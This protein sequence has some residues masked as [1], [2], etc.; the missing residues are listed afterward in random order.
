M[1]KDRLLK[2]IIGLQAVC[3][4]VLAVVVVATVL[5]LGGRGDGKPPKREGEGTP[6][7]AGNGSDA[8]GLAAIATVGGKPITMKELQERLYRQYG[9]EVLR[10]MMVRTAIDLE[11]AAANIS[12]TDEEIEADL[13]EQMESYGG[14]EAFY[15]AMKSQLGLGRDDVRED[16]KYRLLLEK[17]ATRGITVSDKEVDDYL[18]E[19]AEEY[20]PSTRLHLRWIVTESGKDAETVLDKLENGEDFGEL[21]RTYSIDAATSA[22]GGDLGEIDEEDGFLD[23]SILRVAHDLE[24]GDYAGPIATAEGPAVI[25]LIGKSTVEQADHSTLRD[26]VR[27]TIALGMARPLTDVENELLAKYD[28]RKSGFQ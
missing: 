22:S 12:V 3:M 9:D 2:G 6:G 14:E 26:R 19:H 1:G 5:P 27:R 20:A 4:I 23:P 11:S 10:T 28:A 7:L 16:A 21:A 17:I 13:A 15:D 24:P 25:Q 8:G 18:A